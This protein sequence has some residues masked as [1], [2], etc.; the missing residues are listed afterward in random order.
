MIVNYNTAI[1]RGWKHFDNAVICCLRFLNNIDTEDIVLAGF[2]GF[3]NRYN[4]SYCD[5]SLPSLNADGKWDELNS[6]ITEMFKD[7]IRTTQNRTKITFL[8]D[9]IYNVN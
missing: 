9:S 7:V 4:E 8:T 3:K 1:K 6:E 2:D 5:E